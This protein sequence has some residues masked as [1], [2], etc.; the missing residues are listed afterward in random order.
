MLFIK[1]LYVFTG[2]GSLLYVLKLGATALDVN[3]RPGMF[4]I[5]EVQNILD[6]RCEMFFCCRWILHGVQIGRGCL[7]QR[8]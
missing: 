3:E 5:V 6:E 1:V 7:E 2:M 4:S 8:R